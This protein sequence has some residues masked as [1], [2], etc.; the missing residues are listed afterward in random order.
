MGEEHAR[1]RGQTEVRLVAYEGEGARVRQARYAIGYGGRWS[2]SG[3]VQDIE[4]KGGMC[5]AVCRKTTQALLSSKLFWSESRDAAQTTGSQ[6]L[7]QEF[8]RRT[9]RWVIVYGKIMSIRS[10]YS[11]HRWFR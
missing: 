2:R 8:A 9:N 5:R 4:I 6:K 1:V 7:I 11:T 10:Y 3:I